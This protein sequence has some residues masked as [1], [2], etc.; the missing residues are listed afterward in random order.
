MPKAP[1]LEEK[2]ARI[3]ALRGERPTGADADAVRK[4]LSDRSNYLIAKAAELAGE[5]GVEEFVP[6]LIEAF[7]AL[8]VDPIK[9]DKGC[10]GKIAIVEALV[11]LRCRDAEFY[12]KGI[13][14]EQVEPTYGVDPPGVDAGAA[15]R[16]GCAMGLVECEILLDAL[17]LFAE[18][19]AD[20]WKAARIDAIR[21]IGALQSDNGIPLL[22]FKLLLGDMEPEVIGECCTALLLLRPEI[23]LPMVVG[24]LDSGNPHIC[25]EAACSLGESRRA[26][27]FEPLRACW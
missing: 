16:G 4:A 22:R 23:T 7:N 11:K 18:L 6:V 27:A 19:L 13:K 21:A 2:L 9:N 24:V 15:V 20:R 25:L 3:A 12:H 26:E 1:S 14:Y 8:T 17:I 10:L 5:S